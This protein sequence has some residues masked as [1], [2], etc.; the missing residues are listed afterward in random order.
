MRACGVSWEALG[1]LLVLA[2]RAEPR[3]WSRLKTGSV[4]SQRIGPHREDFV[5]EEAG[6]VRDGKV[7]IA[8][9]QSPGVSGAEF[10]VPEVG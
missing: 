7:S 10:R 6:H 2:A 8:R 4:M 5:K 9:Q 1:P 3:W